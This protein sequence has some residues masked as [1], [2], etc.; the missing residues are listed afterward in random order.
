MP[1]VVITQVY[2]LV[3]TQQFVIKMGASYT[4]IHAYIQYVHKF[5]L[6][7]INLIK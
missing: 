4:Y 2:T 6:N 7:K 1:V 5:Y 3:Q